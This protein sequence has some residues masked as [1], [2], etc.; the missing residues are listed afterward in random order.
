MAENI[1]AIIIIIIINFFCTTNKLFTRRIF[2]TTHAFDLL[3]ELHYL[4]ERA[5]GYPE[6][7]QINNF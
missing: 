7:A 6:P 5:C 4:Y 2:N 1:I 3:V